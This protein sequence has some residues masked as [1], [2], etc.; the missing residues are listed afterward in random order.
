MANTPQATKRAAQNR[1]RRLHNA[2]Q[3]SATRTAVKKVIAAA[4]SGDHPATME[5][6]RKAVSRLDRSAA[7]GLLHKNKAARLKQRLN[8]RA[9]AL[10]QNDS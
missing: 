8:A 2:G 7:K 4:G 1:I 3:R 6:Y 5:S 9:K 10:I